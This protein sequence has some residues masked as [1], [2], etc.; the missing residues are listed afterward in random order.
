MF[1][2]NLARLMRQRKY[3][4]VDLADLCDVYPA[5]VGRWLNKQVIPSGTTLVVLSRVLGVPE[6]ELLHG[7]GTGR[8]SEYRPNINVPIDGTKKYIEIPASQLQGDADDYWALRIEK[9]NVKSATKKGDFIV[10][11]HDVPELLIRNLPKPK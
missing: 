4:N 9:G 5:T 7:P 2:T 10:Y 11:N 1:H 8:A 6:H 3:S